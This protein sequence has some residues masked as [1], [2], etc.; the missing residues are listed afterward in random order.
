[1]RIPLNEFSLCRD[2]RRFVAIWEAPADGFNSCFSA[3]RMLHAVPRPQSAS[4]RGML[5]LLTFFFAASAPLF[6]ICAWARIR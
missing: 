3:C 1:L 4:R 5:I 6:T 2:N